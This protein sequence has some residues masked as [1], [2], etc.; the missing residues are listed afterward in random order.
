M[1]L[2]MCASCWSLTTI[3][4]CEM[5]AYMIYVWVFCFCLIEM[6][7]HSES[8]MRMMFEQISEISIWM[9]ETSLVL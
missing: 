4:L 3:C 8:Y 6:H 2:Y 9:K 1:Q 7:N 5:V